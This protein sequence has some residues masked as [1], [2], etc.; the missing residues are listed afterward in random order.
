MNAYKL[1]HRNA[2]NKPL[3][4]PWYRLTFHLPLNREA[5]WNYKYMVHKG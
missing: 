4:R 2:G 3:L 1:S 5:R